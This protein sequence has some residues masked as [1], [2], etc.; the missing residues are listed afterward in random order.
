MVLIFG[1]MIFLLL[2][3]LSRLA[4]SDFALRSIAGAV[5][6]G[7]FPIASLFFG[8]TYPACCGGAYKIAMSIETLAALICGALF[9][10][11]KRRI[12]SLLITIAL[13]CHF[14]MWAWV[15]SSYI[16]PAGFAS[17]L[18]SS[19]YYHPWTRTIGSLSLAMAFHFGF[20]ILGF[21]AALTWVR[22]LTQTSE[23]YNPIGSSVVHSR[24]GD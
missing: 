6:I 22:Y 21:L 24:A 17:A 1:T 20:P 2:R 15:T 9:Y 10:A 23:T 16:N 5:A 3:L 8:L 4:I 14:L 7:A 12:S 11:R 19:E 13:I 18:R